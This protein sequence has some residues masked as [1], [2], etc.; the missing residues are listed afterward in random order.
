MT[1]RLY[2]ARYIVS[3]TRIMSS[4]TGYC[5]HCFAGTLHAGKTPTGSVEQIHGL[6]TYIARPGP[7]V[8]PKALIVIISDGF[9]WE[10]V[11]TRALADSYAKR[12]QYLVYL[13]DFMQGYGPDQNLLVDA[14]KLTAPSQT[15]FTTLVMKPYWL[16]K[17]ASSL[18]PWAF[19]TRRAVTKPIITKFFQHLR[20]NP[21][22]FSTPNRLK[23]GVV[24]FCWGGY[25]TIWL[26]SD[27]PTLRFASPGSDEKPPLIDCGF[28][29]HP[30]LLSFPADIEA[31]KRPLSVANGP[32]DYWMGRENMLTL[33]KILEAKEDSVHEVVV[34]DGARHGFGNR[35]DPNDPKQ[36]EMGL[37]AEDQALNWFKKH[38]G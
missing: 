7:D 10:L 20:S 34:Y 22:P 28:T 36:A 1:D 17:L 38:L 15:W 31:V 24:G 12:G 9:G 37:Q 25:W 35:G 5:R 21:P 29:A 18:L 33:T 30:S 11:N 3:T 27:D 4:S 32:D 8:E 16:L 2:S 23:I 14:D 6:P 26:A 19:W 13:P